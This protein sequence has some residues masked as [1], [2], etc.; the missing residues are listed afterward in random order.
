MSKNNSFSDSSVKSYSQ[1]LY[2]LASDENILQNVEEHVQVFINLISKSS[3]FSILIKDPTFKQDE[4]L[5][6]INI[7]F[8]KFQLNS[9]LKKFIS[10]L[11]K[12]RRFFY[13]D[14]ILRVFVELCSKNRGEITAKLSVAKELSNDEIIK[15]KKDL[16]QNFGSEVK[17]DYRFDPSLIGGLIMQVESIM[18]DTS[19]KN[20]LKQIKNNMIEA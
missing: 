9:L 20:K 17:L 13:I 4:Q 16:S 19:F 8:E 11:I 18:I 1:A 6:I 2:E 12:K 7:I 3:D 10:F 5:K 14:K 15:I